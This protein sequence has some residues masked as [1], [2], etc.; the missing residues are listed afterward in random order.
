M[1]KSLMRRI[2]AALGLTLLLGSGPAEARAPQPAH[3]ALWK[4]SDPD[5][6][7]YLFGTIHL[8]PQA[9]KWRTAKFDQAVESS[10]E[11]V[12]ETIVDQQHP[13]NVLS[14]MFSLGIR[15]GLPP[16]ADR[17]PKAKVPKMR[18]YVARIGVPEKQLDQMETWLA[19]LTLASTE[20]QKMG[21]KAS[22]GP[23]EILRQQFLGEH[24]PIGQLETPSEQFSY[25][26]KLPEAAQRKLFIDQIDEARNEDTKAAFDQMLS[27]WSRGDVNSVAIAFNKD[28]MTSPELKA[29]LVEQRNANWAKWIEQRLGQPGTILVAV[30]AG[31]LAGKGSVI[32]RLQ[33]EGYKVARLQ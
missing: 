29:G 25:F 28:L 6:T 11:L 2:G 10:Q 16:I 24:K 20:L 1:P 27:P 19:W 14:A 3:P 23:E 7:I 12:V 30:G 13:Q 18:A 9:L 8:L 5:T 22:N 32:A 26:A 31:H 17:I 4:V 33:A 21:L 15:P